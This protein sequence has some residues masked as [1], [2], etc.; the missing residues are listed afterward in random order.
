MSEDKKEIITRRDN[1]KYYDNDSGCDRKD[2]KEWCTPWGQCVFFEEKKMP[3]THQASF[4]C[5]ACGSNYRNG[6]NCNI[7]RVYIKDER[8]SWKIENKFTSRST[9]ASEIWN[10][11]NHRYL[12]QKE[13]KEGK[14]GG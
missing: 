2:K 12:T 5:P 9:T 1:C 10:K 4:P 14:K 6:D 8:P 13:I 7:C 3:I 11:A